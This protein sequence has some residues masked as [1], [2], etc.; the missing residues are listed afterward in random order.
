MVGDDEQLRWIGE[1]RVVGEPLRIGV[2][3]RAQDR[4]FGDRRMKLAGDRAGLRFG[5]K[6]TVRVQAEWSP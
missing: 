2:P 1:R 4:Q 6:Q 5:G 3:V